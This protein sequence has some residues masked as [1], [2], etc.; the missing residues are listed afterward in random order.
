MGQPSRLPP[1]FV[2]TL[3]EVVGDRPP[4]A[5]APAPPV[6]GQ[7]ALEALQEQVIHRV[8]QRIDLSLERQLNEAVAKLLLEQTRDLRPR[9]R[10]EIAFAVRQAVSDA[11]A[12][13]LAAR[14]AGPA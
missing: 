2:P 6:A 9:L 4:A 10:E 5:D 14:T 7:H 11:V 13:E 8:L 3:T 1:R 12:E